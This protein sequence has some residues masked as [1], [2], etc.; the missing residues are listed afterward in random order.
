KELQPILKKKIVQNARFLLNQPP[1]QVALGH[2]FNCLVVGMP[3]RKILDELAVKGVGHVIRETRRIVIGLFAHRHGS[4]RMAIS[5][6][7]FISRFH[8]RIYS[9]MKSSSVAGPLIVPSLSVSIRPGM[10]RPRCM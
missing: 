9:R 4:R 1:K 3:V 10:P 2:I 5:G 8:S 6:S 7:A